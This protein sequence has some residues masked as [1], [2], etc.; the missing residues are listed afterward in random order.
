MWKLEI[1]S[2][3]NICYRPRTQTKMERKFATNEKERKKKKTD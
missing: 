3:K 2:I 1:E